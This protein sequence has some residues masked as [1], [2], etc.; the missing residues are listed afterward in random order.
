[1]SYWH[2]FHE[3]DSQWQQFGHYVSVH[4]MIKPSKKTPTADIN[5]P[6]IRLPAKADKRPNTLIEGSSTKLE[7]KKH[8]ASLASAEIAAEMAREA[9]NAAFRRSI[10][11]EHATSSNEKSQV[12][13][14]FTN[15]C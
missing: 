6:C 1:M 10:C 12:E 8:L 3:V 11:K 9:A 13:G 15:K 14:N 7:S 5:T 4:G 2:F